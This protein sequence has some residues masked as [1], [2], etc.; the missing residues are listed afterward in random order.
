MKAPKP[1]IKYYTLFVQ[2]L[3]KNLGKVIDQENFK[4]RKYQSIGNLEVIM[5]I[6]A[7]QRTMLSVYNTDNVEF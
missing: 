5:F 4:Q 3:K 2:K 7:I 1:F 6:T